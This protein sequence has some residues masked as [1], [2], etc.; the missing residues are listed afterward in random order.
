MSSLGIHLPPFFTLF[1]NLYQ[2][3]HIKQTWAKPGAALQTPLSLIGQL[4]H[5]F[6]NSL[7]VCGNNFT[8][9]PRLSG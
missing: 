7:M 6:I 1:A 4:I 9:L 2:L 8:A 3:Y 5:S